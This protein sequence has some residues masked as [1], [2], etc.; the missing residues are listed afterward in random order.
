[1]SYSV[2]VSARIAM[3][4]RFDTIH[5]LIIVPIALDSCPFGHH[6]KIIMFVYTADV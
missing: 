3:A 1:M 2:V 6:S 4:S 5:P